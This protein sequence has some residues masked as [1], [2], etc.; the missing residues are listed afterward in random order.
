MGSSRPLLQDIFDLRIFW[1]F[2]VIYF[3]FVSKYVYPGY[4]PVAPH[5]MFTL[6]GKQCNGLVFFLNLGRSSMKKPERVI[7][8]VSLLS[9]LFLYVLLVCLMP[10]CGRLFFRWTRFRFAQNRRRS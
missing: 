6:R 7:F 4:A 9:S 2:L 3:L 5:F 8:H 10:C 1:Q